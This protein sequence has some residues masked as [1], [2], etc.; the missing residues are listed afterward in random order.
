[1]VVNYCKRSHYGLYKDIGH[2][3]NVHG[4]SLWFENKGLDF[5]MSVEAEDGGL[6]MSAAVLMDGVD[7]I[8]LYKLNLMNT[9]LIKWSGDQRYEF[10]G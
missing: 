3:V 7:V 1:M 5:S 4:H 2:V 9:E 8:I 10:G 6:Q